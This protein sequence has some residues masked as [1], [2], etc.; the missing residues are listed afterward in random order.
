M[1]TVP[2]LR[3]EHLVKRFG[4]LAATDDASLDVQD[5]EIH[6]LGGDLLSKAIVLTYR[7]HWEHAHERPVLC[8]RLVHATQHVCGEGVVELRRVLDDTDMELLVVVRF[9]S[10]DLLLADG[11][12][13]RSHVLIHHR[14]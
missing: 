10:P 7:T 2:L 1:S 12:D 4:G 6:A 5:G 8:R 11:A 14:Q 9:S 3:V 13:G